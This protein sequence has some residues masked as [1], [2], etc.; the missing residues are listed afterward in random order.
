MDLRPLKSHISDLPGTELRRLP[1]GAASGGF[2]VGRPSGA[3][4][5]DGY[6]SESR[7]FS[8]SSTIGGTSPLTSPPNLAKS[9]TR[10][11]DRNA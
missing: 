3:A 10:L 9:F 2:G 7:S 6:S 5:A 4:E 1:T 11:E 8:R